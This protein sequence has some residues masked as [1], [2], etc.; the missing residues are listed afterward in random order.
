MGDCSEI[1]G[2]IEATMASPFI[3][4]SQMNSKVLDASI[5]S[6]GTVH[7]YTYH[8]GDNQLWKWDGQAIRNLKYPKMVLDLTSD[9]V[10]LY[11]THHGGDNQRWTY[12]GEKLVS[13]CHDLVLDIGDWKNKDGSAVIGYKWNGGKNQMWTIEP[14]S[15]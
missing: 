2:P 9:R 14:V 7:M 6:P 4:R 12:D 8:G 13:A 3:I 15:K 11:G 1:A 5:Q 10:I